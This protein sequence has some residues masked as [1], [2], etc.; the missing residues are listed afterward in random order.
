[1]IRRPQFAILLLLVVATGCRGSATPTQ[2]ITVAAGTTLQDSGLFDVLLPRCRAETGIEVKAV[3]VGTGQAL[4]IAKRGDADAL[5]THSPSAEKEFLAAGWAE[6]RTEVFWN[7]FLVV[8]PQSDPAE[9]KQAK[10]AITAL[11]RV[12]NAKSPFVSRGDDSGNHKLEQ[13]LWQQAGIQPKG[14]WYI[15]VG[16]GM[17]QAFRVAN[18]KQAYLLADRGTWLASRKQL[19]LV[20]VHEGDPKLVNQYSVLVVNPEKHAHLHAASARRFAEWLQKPET[21]QFIADFGKDKYGE[22]LFKLGSAPR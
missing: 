14:E 9:V 7:D 6:S 17:A 21:E 20:V 4:E 11:E 19:D 3:A 16:T 13:K 2:T 8:G 18:E 10:D 1:M 5:L 22:A 12:A 15:S